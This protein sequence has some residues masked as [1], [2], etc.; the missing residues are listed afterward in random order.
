M[1]K[2]I[3]ALQKQIDQLKK[4]Q[5]IT[6]APQ[7]EPTPSEKKPETTQSDTEQ[8]PGAIEEQTIE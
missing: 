8:A 5:A 4:T 3:N 6:P 1:G 2:K 7:P